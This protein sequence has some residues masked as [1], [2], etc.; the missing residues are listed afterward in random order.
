M[1]DETTP[2]GAGAA[3]DVYPQPPSLT[4]V[5]DD[6]GFD[7]SAHPYGPLLVVNARR[8]IALRSLPRRVRRTY[9]AKERIWFLSHAIREL[10]RSCGNRCECETPEGHQAWLSFVWWCLE[11]ARDPLL[12][13]R[14]KAAT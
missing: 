10:L 6:P 1:F 2:E 13:R 14:V 9:R 7:L 5:L 12:A 3:E 4:V 11:M 8:E